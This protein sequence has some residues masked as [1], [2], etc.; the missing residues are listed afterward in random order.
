MDILMD[1]TFEFTIKSMLLTFRRSENYEIIDMKQ[2][3][4]LDSIVKM[5]F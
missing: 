5:Q 2:S 1:G 3:I 4:V